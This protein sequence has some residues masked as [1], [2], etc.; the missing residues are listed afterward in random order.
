[1][2]R[3]GTRD[4]RAGATGG[5][6]ADPREGKNAGRKS[7]LSLNVSRCRDGGFWYHTNRKGPEYV[8]QVQ[9]C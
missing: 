9:K 1:M 2:A 5:R 3:C 7:S 8:T 4:A 6:E